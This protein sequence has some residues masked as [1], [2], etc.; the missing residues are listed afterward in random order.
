M[1][2]VAAH[3]KSLGGISEHR[4]YRLCPECRAV[5]LAVTHNT[6]IGHQLYKD[7]IAPSKSGGGI[8]DYEG[9]EVLNDHWNIT[10]LRKASPRLTESIASL[11]SCKA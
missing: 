11:M 9:L 7:E 6:A 3:Y 5:S 8:T 1:K 2:R 10:T 4:L